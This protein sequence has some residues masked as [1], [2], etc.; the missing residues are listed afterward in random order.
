LK[1]GLKIRKR[2]EEKEKEKGYENINNIYNYIAKIGIFKF[3]NMMCHKFEIQIE[4]GN[5][6][7]KLEHKIEKEWKAS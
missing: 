3:H 6:E 2:R 4:L 5:G 1:L 7:K